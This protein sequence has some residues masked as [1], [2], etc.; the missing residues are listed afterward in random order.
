MADLN[1]LVNLIEMSGTG[2][3]GGNSPVFNYPYDRTRDAL[4]GPVTAKVC[5][6]AI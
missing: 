6:L 3:G 5:I 1:R 2:P 4:E